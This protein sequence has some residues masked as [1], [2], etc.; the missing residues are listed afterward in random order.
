MAVHRR[1]GGI[2]GMGALELLTLAERRWTT[3]GQ[4][5]HHTL[6]AEDDKLVL[7]LWRGDRWDTFVLGSPD[8]AKSPLDILDEITIMLA[9]PAETGGR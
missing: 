4:A 1:P 7:R 2:V 8:L 6:H 3:R 9:A 5:A